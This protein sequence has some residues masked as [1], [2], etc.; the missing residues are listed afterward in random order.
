MGSLALFPAG[1]A[2]QG[3][4]GAFTGVVSDSS[5]AVIVGAEVSA[6]NVATGVLNT[7]RSNDSGVYHFPS[8][9]IGSYEVR[10]QAGGFR[11]YVRTGLVVETAQTVRVDAV[12][13]VG[14][15]QETITVT[16]E[17]PLLQRETSSVG[18]QVS[19]A[20]VTNLP[21]QLTGSVRNPF[22]FIG[23]TPGAAGT[24]N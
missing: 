10:V 18:T 3:L 24:S 15:P 19:G 14:A 9:P 4:N 22:A 7:T 1:A 21:Y 6:R 12:L 8:I 16:A 2:A 11:A 5:Q 17:A 23:L 20:M 13:E